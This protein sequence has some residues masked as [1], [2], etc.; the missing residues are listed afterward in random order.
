MEVNTQTGD[1]ARDDRAAS[2]ARKRETYHHGSLREELIDAC[3][4]LIEA[5]GI[6]AVSLRRVAREAGVSPGAPYHHFPDRAALLSAI[7]ARGFE[8]LAQDL[9]AAVAHP[10]GTPG[11]DDVARAVAAYVAFA[12]RQSGHF[13]IMFRPELSQPEKHP[14][15]REA[16]DAALK[17]VTDLVDELGIADPQALAIALWAL[18]HGLASLTLDGQIAHIAANWSTEGDDLL[19]RALGQVGRSLDVVT[20]PGANTTP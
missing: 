11:P 17:V 7:S 10:P 18:A 13:Q 8:I 6:G 4:R 14:A 1:G 12:R 16:G 19:A 20:E 5:E 9:A 3:V 2:G 15:V